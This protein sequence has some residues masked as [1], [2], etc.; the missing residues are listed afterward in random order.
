LCGVE[1]HHLKGAFIL[2]G[3]QIGDHRSNRLAGFLIDELLAQPIA[4]GLVDLPEGDALGGTGIVITAR[5]R[6][7]T[8]VASG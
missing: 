8:A 6:C 2:A 5:A 1:R 7:S 4:G 3:E